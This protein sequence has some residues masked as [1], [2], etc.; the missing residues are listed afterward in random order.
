MT[1]I[2][3]ADDDAYADRETDIKL[4]A[5]GI[6]ARSGAKRGQCLFSILAGGHRPGAE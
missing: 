3:V 2:A 4:D 6:T 1:G 5:V